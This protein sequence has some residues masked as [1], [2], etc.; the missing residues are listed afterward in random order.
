MSGDAARTTGTLHGLAGVD[1]QTVRRTPAFMG[2]LA[3]RLLM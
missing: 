1:L 2:W 3:R